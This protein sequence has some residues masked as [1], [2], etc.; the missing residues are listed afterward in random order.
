MLESMKIND[1]AVPNYMFHRE[2]DRLSRL[3]ADT[4]EPLRIGEDELQD[5]T[6]RNVIDQ[7]LFWL[8]AEEEIPQVNVKQVDKAFEE[9]LAQSAPENAP[10]E[11]QKAIVWSD[12]ES[13]M[14]Q[15]AYFTRLFA[16]IAVTDEQVRREFDENRE[17]YVIPEQI[18]CSHIVRH[19]FGEGV[20]P[21][22]ALQEI[23]EAQKDLNGGMPFDKA[24]EKYSDANGRGGDLGTFTRG[25]ME[26]KFENVAFGMKPGQVSEI[27][28]TPFGYHIVLVHDKIPSLPL[29]F[30]KIKGDIAKILEGKERDRLVIEVLSELKEK[31][32]IERD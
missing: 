32:V 7:F 14:R 9:V 16:D 1:R 29:D 10:D 26:E 3:Q 15:E 30:E 28:Q 24:A 17:K 8:K 5:I 12:I 18:H 2:Y 13:Q 20:D 11:E 31:A 21:N 19:T 22:K 6:E 25:K 23:L 4:P 27:F